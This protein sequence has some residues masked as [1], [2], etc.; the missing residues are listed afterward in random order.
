[1]PN[2]QWQGHQQGPPQQGASG[3]Q[4]NPQRGWQGPPPQQ[5]YGAPSRKSNRLPLIIAAVLVAVAL[6]GCGCLVPDQARRPA[7][8]S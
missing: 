6:I 8:D 2:Q 4:A 5:P 1:M 3:W 7:T